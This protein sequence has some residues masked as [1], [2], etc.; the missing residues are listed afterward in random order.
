MAHYSNWG[1]ASALM[2][3]KARIASFWETEGGG[4]EG[5]KLYS[6]YSLCILSELIPF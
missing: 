2:L 3:S 5:E 6:N 4:T 1:S